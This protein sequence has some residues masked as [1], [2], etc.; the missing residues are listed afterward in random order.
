MRACTHFSVQ[1][2]TFAVLYFVHTL[3][4][5]LYDTPV[6][7]LLYTVV[8]AIIYKLYCKEYKIIMTKKKHIVLEKIGN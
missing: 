7:I 8:S 6:L 3:V 2:K 1:L 4:I 5:V